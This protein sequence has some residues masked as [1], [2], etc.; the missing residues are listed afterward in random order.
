MSAIAGK[1]PAR[2]CRLDI[3][4]LLS[5]GP[6]ALPAIDKSIRLREVDCDARLCRAAIAL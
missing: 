1:H 5:L 3:N 2:A 4:Y 6:Q